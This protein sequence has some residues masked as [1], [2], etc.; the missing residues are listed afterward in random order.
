[1]STPTGREYRPSPE[2]SYRLRRWRQLAMLGWKSQEI[3][4]ELGIPLK[5]LRRCISRARDHGHKDAIKHPI[6]DGYIGIMAMELGQDVWNRRKARRMQRERDQRQARRAHGT[7]RT[8]DTQ[9]D[10]TK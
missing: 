6:T 2:I 5:T 8:Q 7:L 1:M 4:D 9:N 10:N 3:A